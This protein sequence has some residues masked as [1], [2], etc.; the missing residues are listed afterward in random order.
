[1]SMSRLLILASLFVLAALPV[2]T[3]MAQEDGEEVQVEGTAI[4]H[5]DLAHS[6]AITYAL[7]GV[8]SPGEDLEYVG[9]LVSGST[10]LNTGPM[11]REED[12]T[13]NHTFDHENR[14]YTGENLIA[15]YDTAVV[16]VEVAFADPDQP[17]GP[18]AWSY[19]VPT[20]GMAHIRH[21]LSGWP[22]DSDT[23]ILTDLKD[24]IQVAID[25]ANLAIRSATL[26]DLRL[27]A[28]HVI[29]VIEG[30][31]G[32][33]YDAASFGD[34]GDGMGVFAHAR[35]AIVHANLAIGAAPTDAIVVGHAELLK[36]DAQN[37]LDFAGQAIDEDVSRVLP[38]ADL[39][40]AILLMAT[41]RGLL[42]TALNGVDADGSG[43]I[44][45]VAGEGGADQA[46]VEAQLMATFTL[47]GG[48]PL[49]ALPRTGDPAVPLLAQI[50]LIASVALL[51]AGALLMVSG[52]RSRRRA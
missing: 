7:T 22:V 31:G 14:R 8:P 50:A 17:A 43:V 46:Y 20:G 47:A 26:S 44:D 38:Q 2:G 10:K 29:N 37:V 19:T 52:W 23:G 36:I 11:M 41:V 4:I 1:M 45:S 39:D 18:P 24:Q 33:N 42:E 48:G 21:L 32:D 28:H 12:G 3:A 51:A 35:D 5:D 13:V 34:P 30:E 40:V 27:H 9:W 49:I 6:D 16:T 25:H 15:N